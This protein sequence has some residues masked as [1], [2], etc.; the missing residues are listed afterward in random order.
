MKIF[1]YELLMRDSTVIALP[2]GAQILSAQIQH[3]KPMLWCL[4]DPSAELVPG[5]IRIF[6][7]GHPVED[8]EKLK[9]IDTIQLDGGSLIFHVFVEEVRA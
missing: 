5:T 4:V 7:T 2:L 8:C 6:G 3:G 1:K 9:F